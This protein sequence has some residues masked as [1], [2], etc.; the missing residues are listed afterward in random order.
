[1]HLGFCNNFCVCLCPSFV[2][3]VKSISF[4]FKSKSHI[5]EPCFWFSMFLLLQ[6]RSHINISV[7]AGIF[8]FQWWVII[9]FLHILVIVLFFG[10]L[11]SWV[12]EGLYYQFMLISFRQGWL[13]MSS[14]QNCSPQT[15]FLDC[16]GQLLSCINSRRLR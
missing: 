7:G 1:M 14:E 3:K 9:V 16:P 4:L 13:I 6:Q 11:F 5:D 10:G 2:F 15:P 12:I 8:I